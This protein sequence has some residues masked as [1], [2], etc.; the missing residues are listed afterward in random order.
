M[1]VPPI[2]GHCHDVAGAKPDIRDFTGQ[3][4]GLPPDRH[5]GGSRIALG[6]NDEKS[7][8]LV[9][10]R[11]A[12]CAKYRDFTVAYRFRLI[13]QGVASARQKV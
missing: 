4:D 3:A 9:L 13:L 10:T 5:F 6:S 7:V 2:S 1:A 8:L 12:G 11:F